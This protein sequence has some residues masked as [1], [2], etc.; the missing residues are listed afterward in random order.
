MGARCLYRIPH[1]RPDCQRATGEIDQDKSFPGRSPSVAAREV[2][3]QRSLTDA[4]SHPVT[5]LGSPSL[6]RRLS[7]SRD[8]S[9]STPTQLI[10]P[11]NRPIYMRTTGNYLEAL[12]Q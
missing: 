3:V 11:S 8:I 1:E 4:G 10:L 2:T 5:Y 12:S 6:K 7:R 9:D